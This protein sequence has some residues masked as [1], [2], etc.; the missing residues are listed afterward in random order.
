MLNMSILPGNLSTFGL[1]AFSMECWIAHINAVYIINTENRIKSTYL[2]KGQSTF[3]K[4]NCNYLF[5]F[6]NIIFR[7]RQEIL[8]KEKY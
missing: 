2:V 1:F 7:T 8:K 3:Y 5:K 4:N 6:K